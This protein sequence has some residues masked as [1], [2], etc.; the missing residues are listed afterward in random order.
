MRSNGIE[1]YDDFEA[2]ISKEDCLQVMLC[3]WVTRYAM[4]ITPN[5]NQQQRYQA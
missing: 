2:V 4:R 3:M 5:F 1:P